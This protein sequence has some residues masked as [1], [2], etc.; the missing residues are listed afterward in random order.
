[1]FSSSGPPP[2]PKHASDGLRYRLQLERLGAAQVKRGLQVEI[3]LVEPGKLAHAA[4]VC[5]LRLGSAERSGD[6]AVVP[7]SRAVQDN[8]QVG[9]GWRN[10]DGDCAAPGL[11]TLGTAAARRCCHPRERPDLPD[12]AADPP[13]PS[14]HSVHCR[15][16]W[17]TRRTPGMPPSN[18]RHSPPP[19]ARSQRR[20]NSSP[21][22]SA[23]SPGLPRGRGALRENHEN[24]HPICY[25]GERRRSYRTELSEERPVR[26][27]AHRRLQ[28]R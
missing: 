28:C 9:G 20:R 24:H 16:S 12:R 11:G 3:H 19:A 5:H 6:A 13:A 21:P 22:R 15:R 2:R 17:R 4:R 25:V 18:W 7:D 23:R 26:H 10:R 27:L 1:M 14:R 8:I